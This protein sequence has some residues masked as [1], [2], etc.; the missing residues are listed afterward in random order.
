MKMSNRHELIRIAG[1]VSDGE[2][3]K[4]DLEAKL[5]PESRT[6]LDGLRT[7]ESI[8]AAYRGAQQESIPPMPAP[9]EWGPLQII[10][11]I[12]LGSY[13]EVYRAIDPA[14]E[15]EVALKLWR[16]DRPDRNAARVFLSEARRLARV[17]HPNVLVVHG[18]DNYG[19]R[20]GVWTELLLGKTLEQ[21]LQEQGPLGAHEAALVGMSVAR[22]LAAVHGTG[23]IH[24]D[25]KTANV[26]REVGGRI[27][28]MDFGSVREQLRGAASDVPGL[29]T[30][31]FVAP[32]QL[33]GEAVGPPADIYALGVVLYRLVTG[34]FPVEA[35]NFADL[36]DK[37]ERGERVPL[38]D[39]R[40]D[41][42]PDFVRVVE[43]ALEPHPGRRFPTAGALEGALAVSLGS[44]SASETAAGSRLP[45]K[46][47]LATWAVGVVLLA[48]IAATGLWRPW[49][50]PGS[51]A[52][53]SRA[54]GSAV[55][56]RVAVERTGLL[57]GPTAG[58]SNAA[59]V[60]DGAQSV[61]A[62]PT[63]ALTASASLLRWSSGRENPLPS[64]ARVVPGDT[65]TLAIEGSDP[66]YA[67][68]LDEDTKGD[69]F[70]LFPIAGLDLTNPLQKGVRHR[71][72]GTRRGT[73]TGW[74]V[75]SGGGREY[76][77]VLASRRPLETLEREI[78]SFARANPNGPV[79]YGKVDPDAI[80]RL[81]GIG[82][83]VEFT[84]PGRERSPRRL[85]EIVRGLVEGRR[86]PDDPWV[87]SI[88]LENPPPPAQ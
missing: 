2:P 80:E 85:N 8:V 62:S 32:E 18:A 6:M 70:V 10:E 15:R 67:Y 22:A 55:T 34:R 39:V 75:T 74:Q 31:Y 73:P 77:M 87:W 27:V 44:Q 41:L 54:G 38:P 58:G 37:H 12:G 25:V 14:L 29:G 66:M 48:G 43:R 86:G 45:R 79:G 64:G 28:L 57:S 81:R 56:D 84:A 47:L 16:L 59:P 68:V 72:P 49:K 76:V 63:R 7:V 30:P 26:M 21:C 82:R 35:S 9:S 46:R 61:V 71:L 11:R 3:V 51:R 24:R 13:G 52:E 23:L 88:E 83:V 5:Q 50:Q 42:P 53:R 4:W 36:R 17:R 69:V 1:V 33:R 19:G 20:L 40:P 78:A 65:L 60:I